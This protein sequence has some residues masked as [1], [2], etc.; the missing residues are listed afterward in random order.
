MWMAL[1]IFGKSGNL[2]CV[3]QC[4][5]GQI[6]LDDRYHSCA[7]LSRPSC[8]GG[9]QVQVGN[10]FQYFHI[11]LLVDNFSGL[12][13]CFTGTRKDSRWRFLCGWGTKLFS[14]L[15]KPARSP[16]FSRIKKIPYQNPPTQLGPQKCTFWK[17]A[18]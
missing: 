1:V 15:I 14:M 13:Y 12:P 8:V 17:K 2:D 16:G 18:F 3:D 7:Q 11:L 5:R 9:K 4:I 6:V 10:E